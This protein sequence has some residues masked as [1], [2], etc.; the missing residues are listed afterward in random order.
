[1]P[2]TKIPATMVGNTTANTA[3]LMAQE[4]AKDF[5]KELP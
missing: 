2:L 4:Q 5:I 3:I 1:M